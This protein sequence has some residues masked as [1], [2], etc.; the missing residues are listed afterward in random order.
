MLDKTAP[1]ITGVEDGKSYD[2]S[3]VPQCQD[4]DI[5]SVE[6]LKDNQVVQYDFGQEIKESG[7]YIL[8][9]TDRVG[10]ITTIKFEIQEKLIDSD[11]SYKLDGQYI[12]GVEQNT[13]Y[14]KFKTLLNGNVEYTVYRGEEILQ[15]NQVITTGDR[16]VTIYNKTFN[17]VVNGDIS[18]DGQVTIKDFMIL[19][20]Q[21]LNLQEFDD[22]QEKAA[23]VS[24]DKII[25][26]K[27]LMK[28]QRIILKLDE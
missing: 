3:V 14:S 9:V 21:L 20:K 10:N 22:L 24:D 4:S 16:L 13:T 5:E 17:V 28:M 8:A 12:L 27:D 7:K 26:I 25:T 6:L 19:R 11:Y 15:D 1:I 18:K 23:D 2:I